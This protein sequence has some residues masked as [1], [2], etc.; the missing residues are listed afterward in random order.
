MKRE[1]KNGFWEEAY[2]KVFNNYYE[3]GTQR[4]RLIFKLTNTNSAT[5]QRRNL[6]LISIHIPTEEKERY[7]QDRFYAEKGRD[8]CGL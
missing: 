4:R 3:I 1:W 6:S 2:V 5:E 8:L 7:V